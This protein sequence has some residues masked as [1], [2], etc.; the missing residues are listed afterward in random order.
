MQK[1]DGSYVE[2][3][4]MVCCMFVCH[5]WKA[6][7]LF[8]DIPGNENFNCNEFT[9][10]DDYGLTFFDVNATNDRPEICKKAD[11][12]NPLCQLM[13]EYTLLLENWNTI[14]PHAH[15]A[16]TCPSEA[17]DYQRPPNC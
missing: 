8:E 7:G 17:P 3:L 16:E 9:N 12:D 5:M 4:S 13:G 11:P 2:G 6:G 1:N 10:F 14:A 15:M